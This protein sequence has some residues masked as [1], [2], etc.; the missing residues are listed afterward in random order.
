MPGFSYKLST[1]SYCNNDFLSTF[2]ILRSL[3]FGSG[4]CIQT[5]T[6]SDTQGDFFGGLNVKLLTE[7][8]LY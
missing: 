1:K 5:M 8:L 7:Q 2:G 6:R 4:L 3:E